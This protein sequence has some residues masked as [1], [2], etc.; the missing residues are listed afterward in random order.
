M[1]NI[2]KDLCNKLKG[3]NYEE[4]NSDIARFDFYSSDGRAILT[5]KRIGNYIQ[6]TDDVEYYPDDSKPYRTILTL[7]EYNNI[8][9]GRNI[10]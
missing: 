5:L 3:W 2:F 4:D 7:G 10:C 9:L 1:N 8:L 6:L